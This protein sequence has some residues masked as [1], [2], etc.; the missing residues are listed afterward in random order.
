MPYAACFKHKK[1]SLASARIDNA[2][3]PH[4]ARLTNLDA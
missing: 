2:A 3:L 4:L 1:L